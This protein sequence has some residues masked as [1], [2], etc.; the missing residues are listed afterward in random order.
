M[1]AMKHRCYFCKNEIELQGRILN[2]D[3]CSG[4]HRDLHSCVQCRFHDPGYHDQC[5]EPRAEKVRDREQRNVCEF[6]ELG[7]ESQD[8]SNRETEKSRKALDDLF[9]K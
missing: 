7:G 6:F 1:T 4:C 3:V 2:K 9:K 8:R 5:G